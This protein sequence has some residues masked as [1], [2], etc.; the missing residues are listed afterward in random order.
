MQSNSAQND[1]C[2]LY[3]IVERVD[4]FPGVDICTT[5]TKEV[6]F[7]RAEFSKQHA[8]H[9]SNRYYIKS[10]KSTLRYLWLL[11]CIDS[12][13]PSYGSYMYI[14][15]NFPT[16]KPHSLKIIISFDTLEE[17]YDDIYV[18]VHI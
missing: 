9:L 3:K 15:N 4:A 14:L 13:S 8:I 18:Y 10:R 11:L 12:V 7:T 6:K 1:D 16:A 2:L 17:Y 5:T